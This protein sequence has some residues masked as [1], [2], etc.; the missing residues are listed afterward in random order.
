MQG[1]VI[2]WDAK[3]YY[4]PVLRALAGAR[5]AGDAGFWNSHLYAGV[6]AISDPQSWLFVPAFRLLAELVAEPSMRIVDAVQL[7]HLLAAGLGVLVLGRGLGWRPA[8]AVLAAVV[9]MCGGVAAARLQHSLMTVSYAWLPWALLLLRLAFVAGRRWRRVA[10]AVGFGLVAGMM[11]VGRD[12][13]AFLNCVFLVGC[14]AGWLAATARSG[15]W[16]AAADRVAGLLPALLAGAAVLALPMLLTL[17]A[18]AGSTRPEIDFRTAAYAALHPASLLTLIAPDAFGALT[19][20]SYW[21]S[22]TLPWMGLSILGFDWNDQTTS[23]LYVGLVPL[24]VLFV[25]LAGRPRAV[26]REAL[27]P[28]A[29]LAF[30]LAYA[31]GPYTPA[32]RLIFEVVPGV[33]LYRRPNDAAFLVNAML[34]LLVGAAANRAAPPSGRAALLSWA[35]PALLATAL[36]LWLGHRLGHLADMA[37][38]LA[39]AV[40]LLGLAVLLVVRVGPMRYGLPALAALAAADLSWHGTGPTLNAVPGDAIAAYRPE[41]QRLA[42]AIR[43]RTGDGPAPLRVELFGLDAVP[44]TDRGGSWQNAAMAYGFEQTL[45]YDPLRSAAYSEAVG[46]DQNSH[47]P[48]RRLTPLFGGYDSPIA[49]L[50]GIGLVVTGRPIETILPPAARAGLRLVETLPGAWIYENPGTLPRAL[51]VGRAEPDAGGLL[52]RDP[53]GTV[54]IAGLDTAGGIAGPAGQA[55]ITLRRREEVRVRVEMARDGHLVLG[56]RFDP[57]WRATV[58]GREVPVRRANRIFRAVA[59]P[60]GSHE[61]VFSFDPLRADALARALGRILGR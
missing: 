25:A 53:A 32:F 7:L 55:R 42:A 46:A 60:S 29:G 45:G 4:Y 58:D 23:H 2:P 1:R 16:R 31:L 61:V 9:F 18:L 33:D 14:C 10:A 19:P 28:A 47:L 27:V 6:P 38:A 50:L 51:A 17:D 34:A 30:A 49:R 3:D 56:D 21:G 11:A 20:G 54:L 40:P 57:F 44:G 12:Q 52:P 37:L 15:G 59:V 36:G 26:L 22:G 13:V 35:V 8:A 41:G 43:A 5:H 48:E 24:A 39:V